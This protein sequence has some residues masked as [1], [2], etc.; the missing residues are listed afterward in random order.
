MSDPCCNATALS[1]KE[2]PLSGTEGEVVPWETVAALRRGAVPPREDYRL[3]TDWDC[4]VIY[5]GSAGSVVEV[6]DL[7]VRP[8]FKAGGDGL[9]CYCFEVRR[10]DLERDI[11]A[12]GSP[13]IPDHVRSR[14]SAGDCLCRSRNPS[15]ACCLTDLVR[16]AEEIRPEALAVGAEFS[17]EPLTSILR[18]PSLRH[19]RH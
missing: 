14:V 15:G 1:P 7:L 2:C 13:T 5:F 18:L 4:P 10:S 8:G 12:H 3:C 19:E 6:D 17:P 9:V 16:V 11:A